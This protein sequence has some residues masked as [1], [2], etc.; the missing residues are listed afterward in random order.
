MVQTERPSPVIIQGEVD[1]IRSD[2]CLAV[3]ARRLRHTHQRAL[4][5][6]DG[7]TLVSSGKTTADHMISAVMEKDCTVYRVVK[8]E[9][10]CREFAP[11][12]ETVLAVA[13]QKSRFNVSRIGACIF[14]WYCNHLHMEQKIS[15]F[16]Q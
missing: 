3:Y 14:V 11:D 7:I 12:D 6:L 15:M 5:A 4:Y 13:R 9:V 1:E 2:S 16:W 8:D 10:I